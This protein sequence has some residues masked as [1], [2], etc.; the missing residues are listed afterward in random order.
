LIEVHDGWSERTALAFL[1]R[2][3]PSAEYAKPIVNNKQ[4]E[5][6]IPN[7]ENRTQ[8][9]QTNQQKGKDMKQLFTG[10]SLMGL[11]L[12][13]KWRCPVKVFNQELEHGG[14]Q[15]RRFGGTLLLTVLLTGSVAAA[16]ADAVP[17]A[18]VPT[19]DG[20][21]A[22]ALQWFAQMQAGKIDRTQYTVAYGAQLTDDAVQA[23]S[24]QLNEYG[25]SPIR[26][27]IMQK[28][29]VD[30]QTLY[31]VKLVFPRGDAAS[32]LFGFDGEGK[33]TGVVIM[34]MAGD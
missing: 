17:L 15:M 11:V 30:N 23:M 25:A 18:G 4:V 1:E 5:R 16:L 26:A 32:L 20:M 28:R 14:T 21:R 27:E 8:T 24:H 22:F 6:S 13:A 7:S 3:G 29:S 2:L 34:S 12:L 19:E 9:R 31:Q 10:L 33:I